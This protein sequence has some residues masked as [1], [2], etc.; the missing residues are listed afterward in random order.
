M[1]DLKID[2]GEIEEWAEKMEEHGEEF[3]A[4]VMKKAKEGLESERVRERIIFG[5]IKRHKRGTKRFAIV[6]S[7]DRAAE[8][9]K[10]SASDHFKDIFREKK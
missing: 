4:E 8:L 9:L 10:K 5:K 6:K 3:G 2:T 7:P 1:I